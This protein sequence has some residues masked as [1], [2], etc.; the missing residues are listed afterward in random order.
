MSVQS[1]YRSKNL[2][3]FTQISNLLLQRCDLEIEELG[4][5]AKV[6]SFPTDW[7]FRLNWF[8]ENFSIGRTKLKRILDSLKSKGYLHAFQER[9]GRF[10]GMFRY[11]FF[12]SPTLNPYFTNTSNSVSGFSE[13]SNSKITEISNLTPTIEC[14]EYKTES[15]VNSSENIDK[16]N[17]SVN[18]ESII[19]TDN[20]TE[21]NDE[22]IV[23]DTVLIPEVEEEKQIVVSNQPDLEKSAE[24]STLWNLQRRLGIQLRND[25]R[26]TYRSNARKE[27]EATYHLEFSQEVNRDP[28]QV[29]ADFQDFLLNAVTERKGPND[30][31]SYAAKIQRSLVDDPESAQL[32][33]YWVEFKELYRD[34]IDSGKR[35]DSIKAAIPK[36]KEEKLKELTYD[37]LFSYCSSA[38]GSGDITEF[39]GNKGEEVKNIRVKFPHYAAPVDAYHYADKLRSI[40]KRNGADK[41]SFD[42]EDDFT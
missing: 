10:F 2:C 5:L 14:I 27:S 24:Y 29:R 38:K 36:T 31:V 41:I 15:V 3:N 37:Q 4:V 32:N 11:V 8:L 19:N 39:W 12:E 9:S 40:W 1:V 30:P 33:G 6:L 16:E 21:N 34:A 7:Q 25:A 35:F 13:Q 17:Q 18:N 26:E 23:T 22:L 28:K 20:S 42:T